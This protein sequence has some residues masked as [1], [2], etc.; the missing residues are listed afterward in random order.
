MRR[1]LRK[2]SKFYSRIIMKNIG[3]FIA[4]GVLEVF[5]GPGGWLPNHNIYAI[6]PY[7]SEWILP[8]FL[9]YSTAEALSEHYGGVAALIAA[10]GIVVADSRVGVLGALLMGT[11]CGVGWKY[12]MMPM[13]TKVKAGLEL[14]CRN[15]LVAGYALILSLAGYALVAPILSFITNGLEQGIDFLIQGKLICLLSVV[16]EPAKIMFLNNSI[17]YGVL[18]PIGMQQVKEYGNSLL[19]LLE[20][21]PGP[22]IG[23]L[24]AMFFMHEKKRREYG[25]GIVIQAIGGI[26]EIYFPLVLSNLWLILPLVAGGMAGTFCFDSFSAGLSAPPAPGSLITILLVAPKNQILG[27]VSGIVISALVSFLCSL[28]ILKLQG[29]KEEVQQT[30]IVREAVVIRKIGFVCDGGIG[31]SVM[32]ASLLRR[33]LKENGILEIEVAAY[34][35][36]MVPEDIE[37]LVCQKNY[38]PIL[39]QEVG[40]KRSIYA[41]ENLLEIG[42]F[43]TL[44][45]QIKASLQ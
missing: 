14:V 15:L 25:L 21:N 43:D 1:G 38:V 37:L 31:S 17:N 24:L 6:F 8:V 28:F 36:D 18:I 33:K 9:A 22:G 34:A 12:I 19:F 41:V 32:G 3:I 44:L 40:T 16:I 42:N 10:A 11:L 29:E 5:F 30:E 26:H 4:L 23:I 45:E 39:Q 7:L 13:M 35:G 2:V 20:T 27:V